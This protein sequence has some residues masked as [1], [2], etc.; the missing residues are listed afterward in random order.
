M[1]KFLSALTLSAIFAVAPAPAVAKPLLA[2]KASKCLTIDLARR[3]YVS[4]L[5]TPGKDGV[6][7]VLY[8]TSKVSR[9]GNLIR[10]DAAT[11]QVTEEGACV[12]SGKWTLRGR[13][14]QLTFRC[15]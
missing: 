13:S 12:L 9:Q 5:C 6:K 8:Q 14:Q 7:T 3:H 2:V 1:K 15:K 11:L 10:V 4:G